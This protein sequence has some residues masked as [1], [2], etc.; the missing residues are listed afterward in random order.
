[1]SQLTAAKA[2]YASV[3]TQTVSPARLLTML[4]DRLAADLLAGEEAMLRGDVASA[5]EALTHAQEIILELHSTLDVEAWPEGEALGRLYLWMVTELMN[6]RLKNQPAMIADC[7][8]L[9]LPLRDA[10]HEAAGSQ[11]SSGQAPSDQA[12]SGQ[13]GA[14]PT[15]R[16]AG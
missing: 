3:A 14:V 4:Y 6:A 5:G 10:W 1:M 8:R 16:I 11:A 13:T 7:R 2:R 9:V 15:P 12:P